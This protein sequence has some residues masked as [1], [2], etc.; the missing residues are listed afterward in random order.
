[1]SK[2]LSSLKLFFGLDI[3]P[4]GE[5]KNLGSISLCMTTQNKAPLNS[6]GNTLGKVLPDCSIEWNARGVRQM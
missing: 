4:K 1:M 3:K 5:R 2:L 6:I